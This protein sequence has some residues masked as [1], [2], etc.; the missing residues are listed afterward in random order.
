MDLGGAAVG[1]RKSSQL[2]PYTSTYTHHTHLFMARRVNS[3]YRFSKYAEQ[4]QTVYSFS[5]PRSLSPKPL[6]KMSTRS[7]T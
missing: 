7:L 2:P 1:W 4:V 5:T 3:P 6:F